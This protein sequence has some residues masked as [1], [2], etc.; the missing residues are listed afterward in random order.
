VSA[1]GEKTVRNH[2]SKVFAKLH[3]DRSSAIIRARE[4]G[5]RRR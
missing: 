4:A 5:L 1:A 3:V 2:V